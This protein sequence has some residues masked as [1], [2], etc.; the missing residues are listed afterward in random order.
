[1]VLQPL[2][3]PLERA[4]V[5]PE[6]TAVPTLQRAERPVSAA[7]APDPAVDA[8]AVRQEVRFLRQRLERLEQWLERRPAGGSGLR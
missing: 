3:L 2:E 1:M 8:D 5:G 7:A 6:P 4:L